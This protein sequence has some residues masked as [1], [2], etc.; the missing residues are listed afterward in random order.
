MDNAERDANA[1]LI[2]ASPQML[3][4]LK[5]VQRMIDEALPKFDWGKSVLDA[6]AIR[7]LNETPSVVKSAIAAATKET[8]ES[9]NGKD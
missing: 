6:N 1:R 9:F 5:L 7:L 4:A 2:A 8:G 3:E